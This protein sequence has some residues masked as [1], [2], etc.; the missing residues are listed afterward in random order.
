VR[1]GWPGGECVFAAGARIHTENSYK[2]TPTALASLLRAVGFASIDLYTDPAD[3]FVL[4][5][6]Q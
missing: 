4:A 2:T 1:V 5:L 6:A 3:R